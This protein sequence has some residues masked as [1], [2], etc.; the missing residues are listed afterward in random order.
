MKPA[1]GR[2]KGWRGRVGTRSIGQSCNEIPAATCVGAASVRVH[3]CVRDSA[4]LAFND[5]SCV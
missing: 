3:G 1:L 4:V 2:E 5:R